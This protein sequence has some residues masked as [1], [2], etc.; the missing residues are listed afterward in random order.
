MPVREPEVPDSPLTGQGSPDSGPPPRLGGRLRRLA[1]WVEPLL[2]VA[3]AL[4]LLERLGPQVV[5]WTGLPLPVRGE[6]VGFA[7]EWEEA[8]L[9]GERVGSGQ[10]QGQI[11]VVTFWATWCRV[12]GVELPFV[13]R[14]HTRWAESG[15]VR[16]VALSIDQGAPVRIRE[17][18]EEKGYHFPVALASGETRWAFGGIPG[19]PTTFILDR[20]GV[21]RHRLVGMTGPGT[22]QRAVERLLEESP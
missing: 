6:L 18:V 4:F 22:I 20:E 11:Q 1:R 16:V 13:D 14:V 19:V 2:W 10:G 7:P 8:S 17:H 9:E 5:A 3:L 12:C 21:I 15:Q